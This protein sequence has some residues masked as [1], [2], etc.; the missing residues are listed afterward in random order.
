ML[1]SHW[2][3][4]FCVSCAWTNKD[5]LYLVS[6]ILYL[7]L[8][9]NIIFFYFFFITRVSICRYVWFY[10]FFVKS[11]PTIYFFSKH[12]FDDIKLTRHNGWHFFV[13]FTT[14]FFPSSWETHSEIWQKVAVNVFKKTTWKMDHLLISFLIVIYK[15]KSRRKD[16][17]K[18]LQCLQYNTI[19]KIVNESKSIPFRYETN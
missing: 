15:H 7:V 3:Q 18:V 17:L 9:S 4:T 14:G 11:Y 5:I 10:L 2:K 8:Y 1:K 12:I 6:C 19:K 13:S 16:M